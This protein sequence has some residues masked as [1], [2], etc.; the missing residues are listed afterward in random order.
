MDGPGGRAHLKHRRASLYRDYIGAGA[1][2]PI[3]VYRRASLTAIDVRRPLGQ[4]AD[5]AA[6]VNSALVG[7]PASAEP[8]ERS[9][10]DPVLHGDATSH[11]LAVSLSAG[12]QEPPMDVARGEGE[13][14]FARSVDIRKNIEAEA[15]AIDDL[16]HTR[17]LRRAIEQGVKPL[18]RPLHLLRCARAIEGIE[19][20]GRFL[21][22]LRSES[23]DG[24]VHQSRFQTLADL[25]DFSDI[26]GGRR[27]H[28]VRTLVGAV[29]HIALGREVPQGFTYGDAAQPETRRQVDLIQRRSWR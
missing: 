7:G 9:A 12:F 16:R 18:V 24:V 25:D 28:D 4:P 3:Q 1:D 13:R 10:N 27:A 21:Q 5:S 17:T 15:P 8:L 14:A 20:F 11:D 2:W 26:I 29:R 6:E 19:R 22:C 23:L